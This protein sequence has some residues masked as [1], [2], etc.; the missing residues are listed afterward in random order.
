MTHGCL[1]GFMKSMFFYLWLLQLQLFPHCLAYG[2][3]T[4]F[5]PRFLARIRYHIIPDKIA[6]N[7]KTTII[8]SIIKILT[9]INYFAILSVYSAFIFLLLR[10]IRAATTAV[11][12]ATAVAPPIAAPTFRVPPTIRVPTV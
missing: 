9:E 2:H 6:T 4:H 8:F 5:S 7:I 11:I 1:F 3:P 10:I 12:A